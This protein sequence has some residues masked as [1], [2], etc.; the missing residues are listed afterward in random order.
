MSMPTTHPVQQII[1]STMSMVQ[2]TQTAKQLNTCM[3]QQA[4]SVEAPSKWVLDTA[5][6]HLTCTGN[7]GIGK[8]LWG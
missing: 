5:M 4:S 2:A 6:M 8:R 7:S 1:H 3:Q